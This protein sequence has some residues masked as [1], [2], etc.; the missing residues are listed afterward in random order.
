MMAARWFLGMAE[1]GLFPG[2]NYYLSCW[3]K[4]NEF[5]IRAAIFFSA[6]A[7]SG[8]FGGLLAAAIGQMSGVGGKG[9]WAWIFILEGIATV[10]VGVASFWMVFDF[11]D[12][13]H[14]LSDIDRQR[15]LRRLKADQQS[16]A[17]HEN[18]KMEYFWASVKDWKTWLYA[19]IY[20]GADGPL[21]AFSLFLPS[22]ISAVSKG[23][24]TPCC[25]LLTFLVITARLQIHPSPTPL[26]PPIRRR[27]RPHHNNRLH[28]RPHPPAR[29]LQHLHLHNRHGRLRHAHRRP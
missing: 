27:R 16:S 15:V 19:I 29:P 5:G 21:Y 4:R 3:Y 2:I 22:I 7:V 9:G 6:A 26:R 1:A 17:E 24:P 13:A 12:E 8:S 14:F 23:Y 18:F 11:P 25:L 20:M 28:R 10:L